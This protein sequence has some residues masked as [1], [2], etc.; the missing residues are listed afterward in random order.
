MTVSLADLLTIAGGKNSAGMNA[1]PMFTNSGDIDA[2]NQATEALRL[3]QK[4][5]PNAHVGEAGDIVFDR[6]LLPK[7][8]AA[9]LQNLGRFSKGDKGGGF[10]DYYAALTPDGKGGY[11][12][13]GGADVNDLSK[14]I[15]DPNYGDFVYKGYMGQAEGDSTSGFMGQLGKYAPSVISAIMSMATGIP[16]TAFVNAAA[17]ADEGGFKGTSMTNLLSLIGS[18]VA[19]AYVP[20]SGSLINLAAGAAKR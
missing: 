16:L 7:P 15:H 17:S 9:E 14:V 3:A 4:Y 8:Q 1:G 2:D 5:D 6:S 19:N 18:S 20:G 12:G 11:T 10:Y 13:N